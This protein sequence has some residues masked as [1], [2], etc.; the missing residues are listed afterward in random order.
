MIAIEPQDVESSGSA[1][2]SGGRGFSE[3]A[4]Q[5]ATPNDDM[6]QFSQITFTRRKSPRL[7]KFREDLPAGMFVRNSHPDAYALM[8]SLRSS[9]ELTQ[10]QC[11]S[12]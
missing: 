7:W 9:E 8:V 6:S 4:G 11:K 5:I 1:L 10:A 12:V 3:Q 2:R